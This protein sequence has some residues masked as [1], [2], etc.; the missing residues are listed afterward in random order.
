MTFE[1]VQKVI[2]EKME[3]DPSI[4]TLEATLQDL[5]IDSLDM[6]DIIMGIEEELDISLDD[7][8]DAKT[9]QD[10]VVFIDAKQA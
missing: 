5:E 2:A 7:L 9:V 1:T 3:V 8:T 10:V 4:V 6:M